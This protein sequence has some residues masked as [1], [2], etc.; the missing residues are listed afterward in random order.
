MTSSEN[1]SP[2]KDSKNTQLTNKEAREEYF[3]K[4]RLWLTT[5]N[6]YQL[7]YNKLQQ[8]SL[9]KYYNEVLKK[10]NEVPKVVPDAIPE[11]PSVELNQFTGMKCKIPSLWKRFGAEFVDFVILS[12]FKFLI[13]YILLGSILEVDLAKLNLVIIRED[14]DAAAAEISSELLLIELTHRSMVC[15][16]EVCCL[17]G[18]TI[19]QG[20]ATIGKILF[21]ITVVRADKLFSIRGQ[22]ADV[23]A[24]IPG[25]NIGWKRAIIRSFVKNL[26]YTFLFP[27]PFI[28]AEANQN[29]CAYDVLSGAIVVEAIEPFKCEQSEVILIQNQAWA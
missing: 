6:S 18:N 3:D 20:K 19:Y 10:A 2:S 4:L 23:I 12:F 24:L 14:V 15:L 28:T 5:V 27:L 7:Y 17:Q 16:Y 9:Q 13:A 25:S 8:E 29:R 21:N 11:T 1:K 26:F 22:P